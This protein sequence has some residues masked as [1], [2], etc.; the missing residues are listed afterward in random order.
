M[1]HIETIYGNGILEKELNGLEE[2]IVVTAQIPWQL[3]RKYFSNKSIRVIMPE[4]LEQSALD[5]IASTIPRGVEIVGLGGGAVI[6]AAKYFAYLKDKTPLLI[7][8][9]TSSN[10]PFSDFI[11]VRK[12]GGPF[13]FKKDGWPKKIIV[14]Y[15]LIRKADPRLNRAGYGDLLFMQ[16][17][18]N[19]WRIAAAS[20][21]GVPLDSEVEENMVKMIEHAIDNAEEI[22][23]VTDQGIKK[24]M[25]LTEKST[26]LVMSNLSKPISAGAEHLFAWNLEIQ[27]GRNFIHG[28]IV[29]LG[30]VIASFLQKN[31]HTKLKQAL[32]KAQVIY[33]PD[34]LGI[35]WD[36]VEQ[37]LLTV[38]SYNRKVRR[39]YTVFED[40]EWTPKLFKDI[41]EWIYS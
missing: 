35:D 10:A 5:K 26:S 38:K 6:D 16:T 4:T 36:E 8:T 25:E 1:T 17:T 12:G 19:D 23:L 18:L 34:Q 31:D 22:G 14:D 29:S 2:Y 24:L 21:K 7:P 13:G 3:H 40:V 9:I 41:K 39:F 15:E 33:L 30:I 37:V 20:G 32:D 28:E 11:S 27:T